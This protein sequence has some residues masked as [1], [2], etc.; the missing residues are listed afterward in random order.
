MHKKQVN[1][2]ILI[3]ITQSCTKGGKYI[4]TAPRE[5][6][7]ALQAESGSRQGNATGLWSSH[8]KNPPL[9]LRLTH[10]F[11]LKSKYHSVKSDAQ[12]GTHI[13]F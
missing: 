9:V 11:V 7:P 5:G 2:S 6:P 12:F 8:R 1:F 10:A 3:F 13:G 4:A